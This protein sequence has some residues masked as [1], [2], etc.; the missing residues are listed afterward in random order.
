MLF[1]LTSGVD[2]LGLAI[3]F[4]L[5]LYLLARGF[6][7]RTTIRAVIALLAL[8]V[9]FLS[10]S[11]NLWIQTP[12][13]TAIRAA[14]LTVGLTVWCD[15][16][17]KLI[18]P[19]EQ[20]KNTWI[21]IAIYIFGFMTVTL[22]LENHEAFISEQSN[23]LWVGR[24][25]LGIQYGVYGVFQLA[26]SAAILYNLRLGRKGKAGQTNPYFVAASVLAVST[27]GYG[28]LALALTPPLPRLIQDALI[29][30][31]LILLGI[32]VARHQTLIERRTTLHELPISA[33]VIFILTTIYALVAW[34]WS[35]SPLILILITGLVILTHSLYGLT[36]EFLVRSR[37]KKESEYRN[38]LRHLGNLQPEASLQ[39]RLEGGLELL[40][41]I[42][43][44]TGAFIAISQA[45]QFV[46]E[47][48][49]FSIA[50]GEKLDIPDMGPDNIHEAP[51]DLANNVAWL[52][53]AFKGRDQ[54]AVIG[55]GFPKYRHRYSADDLDLLA[56]AADRVAAIVAMAG[57]QSENINPSMSLRAE[58]DELITT[59]STNPDPQFV[60]MVEDG[61]RNLSDIITL[62]QSSLAKALQ[63]E[64]KTHID[65]GKT[66]RQELIEAIEALHPGGT[67]PKEPLPREWENYVV[68]HDA[69]V[70]GVDNREIMSRL[71]T[72][73][74][75]FVRSRRK[76]LR[77]VARF[78]LE[79][80]NA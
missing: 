54:L 42:L 36:A 5:A 4:W 9:F 47:V 66:L 45:A 32:S 24:M 13:T 19:K 80:A 74:S 40:C 15:L 18:P 20:S 22:L 27:V 33:L 73:E 50:L 55:I 8:S 68:L 52:V 37:Y 63:I 57:T 6:P 70:E 75:T 77:G 7:S 56:E 71:Y 16:T 30:S 2:F 11:L 69:Y 25:N 43:D 58:S 31:S 44:A 35:H 72:S 41:Q 34:A 48:S 23:L 38:Q 10:A 28:I 29:I 1:A 17:Q 12:G 53:P 26:A 59:L 49:F 51:I 78:L 60:K 39:N 46:V 14:L 62:G 65:R 79:K 3:S 64:G 67:R 76:A 61:L 21:V